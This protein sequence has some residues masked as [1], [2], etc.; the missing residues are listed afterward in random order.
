M[1]DRNGP[2]EVIRFQHFWVDCSECDKGD[3]D[4]RDA[5]TERIMFED[6][7]AAHRPLCLEC[8]KRLGIEP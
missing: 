5:T 1:D 6:G 3:I 7:T 2:I 8:A 4:P